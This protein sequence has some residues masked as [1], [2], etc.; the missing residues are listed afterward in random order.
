MQDPE[1]V[2][3]EV[4]PTPEVTT[5]Y[6]QVEGAAVDTPVETSVVDLS[7]PWKEYGKNKAI[8]ILLDCGAFRL[9][10]R[11]QPGY[12][13]KASGSRSGVNNTAQEQ[14]RRQKQMR[15]GTLK[16]APTFV[17]KPSQVFKVQPQA[18]SR[19]V[20]RRMERKVVLPA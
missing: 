16:M 3:G 8:D 5:E 10:I 2:V 9:P 19:Q 18:F 20:R 17:P 1:T 6:L 14:D 13:K 11:M 12:A 4:G 7:K 15:A